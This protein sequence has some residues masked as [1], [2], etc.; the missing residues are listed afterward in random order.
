MPQSIKASD[1]VEATPNAI[2]IVNRD[3]LI[4]LVNTAAERVFGYP[5]A[6]LLSRPIEIL[7][8]DRFRLNHPDLRGAYMDHLESRPMGQG[9]DLYGRR[10][11]GTEFPIEI[12]LNPIASEK[13]PMVLASIVDISVRKRLERDLQETSELLFATLNAAPFPILVTSPN[14]RALV[15]N[16]AGERTFGYTTAEMVGQSFLKLVPDDLRE[17]MEQIFSVS[18]EEARAHGVRARLVHKDGRPLTVNIHTA[19]IFFADGRLRAVVSTFEDMTQREAIENQ[20]RQ[21]QKME[22]IGHLTGGIAHDFN[23]LLG[24]I[25]GNL[26]LLLS[27]RPDDPESTALGSEAM[28]AAQRGAELTRQMLAFARRQPLQPQLLDVNELIRRMAKLL[29]RVLRENIEMELRLADD[30][31][32]VAAD[33]TQLEAALTNLA[34]NARDAMPRGGRLRIAT[35]RSGLDADYALEH[36]GVV[37]GDY[38]LLEVSDTGVGIEPDN[39]L[40]IFEPFFSTKERDEGTGLGLSMVFG[41][42]KQSGGHINVYSE[43]GIGSTF[44]LYLPRVADDLRK[45]EPLPSAQ[46]T[47]IPSQDGAIILVAEDNPALRRVVVRQLGDIGYSTVEAG[48]AAEAMELLERGGVDLLFSDVI[49][50]GDMDGSELASVAI[51]RW[52]SL[53]VI[54]TSGFPNPRWGEASPVPGLRLLAKPYLKEE[55][56]RVVRE[57][58]SS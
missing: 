35:S 45:S 52:P 11:D 32:P 39:I 34:T 41:F 43:V 31:W 51:S 14:G 1:V 7:I 6:E 12:G 8:P 21:A 2:I 10:R 18:S 44:R 19:P 47:A 29:G 53:K 56:A 17:A 16:Q 24:V 54:L 48:N 4:E 57:V 30:I 9:R 46:P 49:M 26:D 25:M 33:A 5:R 20:L 40:R 15:F 22:A 55:L 37:P 27:A 36:P 13:G 58:L 28:E 42:V 50:P 23:N 38:V 3:G